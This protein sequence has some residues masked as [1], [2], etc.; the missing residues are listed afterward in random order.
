MLLLEGRESIT[1]S[2]ALGEALSLG[3]KRTFAPPGGASR[4]QLEGEFPGLTLFQVELSS[5]SLQADRPPPTPQGT[6]SR[7]NDGLSARQFLFRANSIRWAEGCEA[8]VLLRAQEADLAILRDEQERRWLTFLNVGLGEIRVWVQGRDLEQGLLEIAQKL[9]AAHGVRVTEAQLQLIPVR[10]DSVRFELRAMGKMSLLRGVIR[11]GGMLQLLPTVEVRLSQLTASGEGAVGKLAAPF[12]ESTL[13][14]QEGRS[15]PLLGH[16]LH[17][18]ELRAPE[19]QIQEAN[20]V[21]MSAQ[22]VPATR[23]S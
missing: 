9:T 15:F 23:E 7:E 17:G 14:K 2:A 11:V 21:Q 1:S 18:L 19:I 12:L 6:P 20:S 16:H 5:G 4:I 10:A 13:R 3:L 8:G 22:L